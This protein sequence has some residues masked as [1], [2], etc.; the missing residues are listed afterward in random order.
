MCPSVESFFHIFLTFHVVQ[1]FGNSPRCARTIQQIT[2][3]VQYVESPF[4][5]FLERET[6]GYVILSDA[7]VAVRQVSTH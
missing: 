6:I 3:C 1:Y 5:V 4:P 2:D 7:R